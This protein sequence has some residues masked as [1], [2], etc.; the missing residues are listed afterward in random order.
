MRAEPPQSL[1]LPKVINLLDGVK[2]VLHTL[3]GDILASL[4]ALCLEDF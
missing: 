4:D 1:Y 2:V 3:D